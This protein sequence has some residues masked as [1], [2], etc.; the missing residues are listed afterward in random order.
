MCWYE[1][2]VPNYNMKGYK[3]C[4]ILLFSSVLLSLDIIDV[5]LATSIFFEY[6]FYMGFDGVIAYKQLVSNFFIA[7]PF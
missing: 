5:L 6:I 1:T 7:Q 2:Y 3:K 4:F